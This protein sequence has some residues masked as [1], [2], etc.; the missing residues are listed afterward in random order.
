MRR[1]VLSIFFMLAFSS[2]VLADE[3]DRADAAV[4]TVLFEFEG[5]E[6]YASYRANEDGS[7]D[8]IFARNT[9]DALYEAILTRLQKHPDISSVLASKGGPACRLF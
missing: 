8:L 1:V 6:E 7:V 4:A 5:S 3:L 9:P 2:A